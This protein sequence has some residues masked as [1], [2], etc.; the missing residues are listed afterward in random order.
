MKFQRR[1]F[2]MPQETKSNGRKDPYDRFY[3]PLT[4]VD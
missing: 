4:T 1:A 3:T 2:L